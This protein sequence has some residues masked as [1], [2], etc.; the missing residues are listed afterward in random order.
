[1]AVLHRVRTEYLYKVAIGG[2]KT[3]ETR[4]F[5]GDLHTKNVGEEPGCLSKVL[6][7]RPD[8]NDA[9]DLQDVSSVDDEADKRRVGGMDEH[10]NTEDTSDR[11][12]IALSPKQLVGVVALTVF[13]IFLTR[14][15]RRAGRL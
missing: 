14:A 8:P 6:G 12:V 11:L 3:S 7:G 15:R 13:V 10:E 2:G 5:G 1:M 4:H 9:L